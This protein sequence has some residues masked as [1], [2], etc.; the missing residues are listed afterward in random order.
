MFPYQ[1]DTEMRSETTFVYFSQAI[2]CRVSLECESHST[3]IRYSVCFVADSF[4]WLV[5]QQPFSILELFARLLQFVNLFCC[6]FRGK[7]SVRHTVGFLIT[8]SVKCKTTKERAN[9]LAYLEMNSKSV[10]LCA[11]SLKLEVV[12]LRVCLSVCHDLKHKFHG[13]RVDKRYFLYFHVS[14]A[15][16]CISSP[17]YLCVF[18]LPFPLYVFSFTSYYF[19]K[20]FVPVSLLLQ[21]CGVF[22]AS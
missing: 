8:V 11:H 4:L 17:S 12:T 5:C 20:Y 15:L 16:I 14:R 3:G 19:F 1:S 22:I 6:K 2:V 21:V 18:F 10:S 13:N 7:Y 9:K